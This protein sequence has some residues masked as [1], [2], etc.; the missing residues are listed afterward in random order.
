MRHEI[1][2]VVAAGNDLDIFLFGI[3]LQ[4]LCRGMIFSAIFFKF[5]QIEVAVTSTF[6]AKATSKG[7]SFVICYTSV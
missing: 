1:S 3:P 6:I 2:L 4:L 7:E 5:E